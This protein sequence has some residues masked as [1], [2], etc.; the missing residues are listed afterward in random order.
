MTDNIIIQLIILNHCLLLGSGCLL[1]TPFP[2][3]TFIA[4]IVFLETIL[5]YFIVLYYASQENDSSAIRCLKPF[6]WIV[7]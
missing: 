4:L 2:A 5:R 7:Y 1:L 6:L 3:L